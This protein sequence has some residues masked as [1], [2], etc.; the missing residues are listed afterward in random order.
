MRQR[1]RKQLEKV[2]EKVVR[3]NLVRNQDKQLGSGVVHEN[4]MINCKFHGRILRQNEF[5]YIIRV[6]QRFLTV[7]DDLTLPI[8]GY[9]SRFNKSM[10]AIN[11]F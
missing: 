6:Q 2:E 8:D 1:A 11:D 10:Q 9:R 5:L 7:F 4:K 3:H